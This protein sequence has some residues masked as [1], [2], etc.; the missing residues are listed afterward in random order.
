[1]NT[2][3]IILFI[4]LLSFIAFIFVY[5]KEATSEGFGSDKVLDSAFLI[6]LGGIL[7]GK[8]LFRP[9]TIDYFSHRFLTSPIILEGV[10]IGGGVTAFIVIRRNNWS[11]WKI[12]DMIAPALTIFQLILFLGF[13]LISNNWQYLML[14]IIFLLLFIFLIYLKNKKHFGSSHRFFELQRINELAFT[15]GLIA[16]YLTV[17]SVVAILFLLVNLNSQSKFWWF[18]LFFYISIVVITLYALRRRFVKQKVNM[19]SVKGLPKSLI[20]KF[21]TSLVN[22]EKEIE[23]ELETMQKNDPFTVE[24]ESEGSRQIDEL[25]DDVQEFEVHDTI[26][27]EERMLRNEQKEIKKA[28]ES[29]KKGTYGICEKCGEPIEKKR[30]ELEPTTTLCAKCATKLQ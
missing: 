10:L 24:S 28:L 20:N 21:K 7:G 8:L 12:G 27:S 9:I 17:S 6:L 26:E 1:M 22:R 4:T 13:Y 11:P 30:L 2:Q 3:F 18:Q 29:I 25:G 5:W 23:N 19:S 16:I 15:G 14:S